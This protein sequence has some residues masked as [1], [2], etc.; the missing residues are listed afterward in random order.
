MGRSLRTGDHTCLGWLQHQPEPGLSSLP[1]GLV[2]ATTTSGT[3]CWLLWALRKLGW[4]LPLV[5]RFCLFLRL[6]C[7]LLAGT[8][9]QVG[10]CALSASIH[11]LQVHLKFRREMHH[12][13]LPH[14]LT[15]VPHLEVDKKSV[16][17]LCMYQQCSFENDFLHHLLSP[18]FS[19]EHNTL[20][21]HANWLLHKQS[22]NGRRGNGNSATETSIQS[23][24]SS[25]TARD[26]GLQAS[27]VELQLLLSQCNGRSAVTI[28]NC[29]HQPHS[30]R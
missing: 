23:W 19:S 25:S 4:C 1:E 27:C 21:D 20:Q 28:S 2:A 6:S 26:T 22:W 10:G 30:Q 18:H 13:R 17:K 5:E 15:Q 11:Q 3:D 8:S 29:S 24:H 16:V 12:S 14:S 7:W 9:L